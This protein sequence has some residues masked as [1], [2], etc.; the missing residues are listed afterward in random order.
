MPADHP[1][2]KSANEP[3]VLIVGAGLGGVALALL[4][5][6]AGV[7][8][9]LYDRMK[10]VK[11]LGAVLVVGPNI[12]PLFRQLGI[13][14]DLVAIAKEGL[15]TETYTEGLQP[16]FSLDY[17]PAVPIGGSAIYHVARSALY[18]LLLRQ[19]PAEKIHLGKRLLAF[20]QNEHGV[21]IQFAD[22]SVAHGDILVGADGA[23]SGVRQSLY[24]QLKKE[25][26]LPASD[27]CALPF[28]CVCLVGQTKPLDPT[29]YPELLEKYSIS[30]HI[31]GSDKPYMWGATTLSNNVY[32]WIAIQFLNQETTKENDSFRN[33][34]WGPEAAET[35]A[36]EVRNFR[37]PCGVNND[38]TLG[39]LIDETPYVSKVLLEEKVFDTWYSGRTVL[40]GDACHKFHP[41][42]GLGAVNAFHD[43]VALAN[44]FSVMKSTSVGDLEEIFKEYK[45]E[46]FPSAMAA[47]NN[48]KNVT[49]IIGT[50]WKA[51]VA[52][53]VTRNMPNWLF[54]FSL[55][56]AMSQRPQVSFLPL[57]QDDGTLTPKHQASL[58]KTLAIH[59]ANAQTAPAKATAV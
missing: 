17:R 29:K 36:K 14:D 15:T 27:D 51:K 16:D 11:P 58:E 49:V 44:W 4:L 45:A 48:G 24:S 42:S 3:T 9:Q 12:A 37:I 38:L 43:A 47:Y 46:R 22:K 18:D 33:S 6:K 26:K 40:L 1:L 7:P 57:V 50:D 52:R 41:A 23:Y 59:K 2:I 55:R 19:I 28:S 13:Y 5:E 56:S 25:S 34:E 8:Y 32:G 10:E 35:M 54:M 31:L 53:F 21:R 30:R 39:D 20:Q